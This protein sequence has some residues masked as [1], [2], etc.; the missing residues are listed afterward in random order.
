[1][2]VVPVTSQE[3]PLVPPSIFFPLKYLKAVARYSSS[4]PRSTAFL[5]LCRVAPAVGKNNKHHVLW[6][7]EAGSSRRSQRCGTGGRTSILGI[8]GGWELLYTLV[9]I[10]MYVVQVVMCKY[11]Y[12]DHLCGPS[13]CN[14]CVSVLSICVQ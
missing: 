11:I 7:G 5:P 3:P 14:V 4:L 8:H 10:H 9:C 13:C 1:M 12:V 2:T 6:A